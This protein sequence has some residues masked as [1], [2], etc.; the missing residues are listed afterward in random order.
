MYTPRSGRPQRRTGRYSHR[1]SGL[2]AG[3]DIRF[4]GI[5]ISFGEGIADE[6]VAKL[7]SLPPEKQREVL[8]FV[9]SLSQRRVSGA[10]RRSVRGLWKDLDIDITEE[11]IAEARRGMWGRSTQGPRPYGNP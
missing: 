10:P 3:L 7:R 6:V 11:H 5:F 8:N 4:L 9:E 1:P 2:F